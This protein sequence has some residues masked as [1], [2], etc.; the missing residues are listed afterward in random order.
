MSGIS[1]SLLVFR[2]RLKRATDATWHALCA[3][4]YA[5][6][7]WKSIPDEDLPS[8]IS[9]YP[10]DRRF[11]FGAIKISPHEFIASKDRLA[12][13]QLENAIITVAGAFEAYMADLIGR[14]I[15]I[16]PSLLENSEMEIKLGDLVKPEAL[17]APILWLSQEFVQKTVRNKSHA[18]LI[19]RYGSMIRRDIAAANAQDFEL[20][21]KFVLLR[22]AL[23][24]SA[25]IVTKDLSDVWSDRFPNPKAPITLTASDV[26]AGHKA[27]YGLA[28]TIDEFALERVIGK[29][30]AELL[31]REFFVLKG[32][33]D[34]AEISRQIWHI[35]GEKYSKSQVEAALAKQRREQR[36]PSIEFQIREDWMCRP[37]E[38]YS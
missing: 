36:D 14:C 16:D 19:I 38:I 2:H 28:N 9:N 32:Q 1:L 10:G 6:R 15:L 33:T 5:E 37:H 11:P 27:A 22:N 18:K 31:A 12:E 24:H 7:W 25:G 23:I 34:A 30:D 21:N 35:L 26:K 29:S 8:D 20:W 3:Q 13:V 4:E 17:S